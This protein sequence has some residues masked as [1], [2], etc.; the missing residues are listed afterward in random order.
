[1]NQSEKAR[2][3]AALH[4]K[5]NPL[6]L[7][8]AWDAGSA[9]AIAAA[10]A[11]AI[12]TSSW[13]VA[14]ALGYRDGEDLPMPLALETIG[15]IAAAVDVPVSADFEGGYSDDDA[16]MADNIGRLLD[17]GIVGINFEDRVVKGTGLYARDH[18]A[19]RIEA[20]RGAAEKRG[21]D[22]F[23]NARTDIFFEHFNDA[24]NFVDEAIDQAKAYKEAGASSLF[25]PGLVDDALIERVTAGSVLPVN[26][27]VMHGVSP[28]ARLAELGV[29]RVSFGNIPY[30]EAMSALGSA[31]KRIYADKQ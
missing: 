23:I 14:A 3:F 20:I 11:P 6:K 15:R 2:L 1:M 29:A 31:A 7:F 24:A 16:T 19:G 21:I 17:T 26:V 8:N 27:M 22:L 30:V 18:Q 28:A 13:A 12:A 9:R 10:G 5:G 25:V 4:V